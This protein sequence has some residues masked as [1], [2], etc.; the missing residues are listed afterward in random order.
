MCCWLG[1]QLP[2]ATRPQWR[3]TLRSRG[4]AAA[5]CR[6]D[7]GRFD[8]L[9]SWHDQMHLAVRPRRRLR[10]HGAFRASSGRSR[11]EVAA[12]VPPPALGSAVEALH[13]VARCEYVWSIFPASRVRQAQTPPF[14][15]V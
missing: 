14:I 15:R 5:C 4:P 7:F 11:A 9:R 6:A 12:G 13:V 10:P 3:P 1:V 2:A 8:F